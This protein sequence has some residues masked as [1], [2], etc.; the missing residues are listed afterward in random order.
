MELKSC[1]FC[2]KAVAKVRTVAEI[3][4]TE[5]DDPNFEWEDSHYSVV[6]NYNCGGCGAM[7]GQFYDTPE[8]AAEAWNRRAK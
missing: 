5:S 8:A 7:I 1:P 6:C 3:E 2:G 4:L